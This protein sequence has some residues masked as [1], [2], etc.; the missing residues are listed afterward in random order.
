VPRESAESALPLWD[1]LLG[2]RRA[3]E[4]HEASLA[5]ARR[6]LN[7]PDLLSHELA[8]FSTA[9]AEAREKVRAALE[10]FWALNVPD[11]ARR[12]A[13]R[14]QARQAN[15]LR[16]TSALVQA[17]GSA[18]G[19]REPV[20]LTQPA[21]ILLGPRP[22]PNRLTFATPA[23]EQTTVTVTLNGNQRS[24]D[25]GKREQVKERARKPRRDSPPPPKVVA[26]LERGGDASERPLFLPFVL[27]ASWN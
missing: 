20:P 7:D 18:L 4:R 3:I 19:P 24:Q 13:L 6:R 25:L 15:H 14:E 8:F 10:E 23:E 12:V 26:L 27:A 17:L 22:T 2:K 9:E 5:E 1:R 16:S 11:P 21:R